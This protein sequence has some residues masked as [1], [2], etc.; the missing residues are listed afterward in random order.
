MNS[1]Q[2]RKYTS[3]NLTTGLGL[4]LTGGTVRSASIN[5]RRGVEVKGLWGR[6]LGTGLSETDEQLNFC[7]G[8][9]LGT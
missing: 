5:V 4:E 1:N 6:Q 7:V 8:V 2:T 3:R 9:F